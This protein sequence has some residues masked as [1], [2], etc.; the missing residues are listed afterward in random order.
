MRAT[1]HIDDMV[2]LIQRLTEK[3]MTYVSDGSIYFRI[4]KFPNYGKL[5]KIRCFRDPGRRARGCGSLR[6]S[7]RS[8]LRIMERDQ[9]REF[10]LGYSDSAAAGPGGTSNAPPWR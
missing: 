3:G 4:S 9:A 7:R 6:K 8:R 2:G 10:Y 1:D 5:I